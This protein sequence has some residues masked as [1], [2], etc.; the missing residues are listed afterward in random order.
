M[1]QE[2]T[3]VVRNA[4]K[5]YGKEQLV[6]NGL[7]MTVFKGSIYGLLGASGCGKTTLLS[8]IV[9]V[10]NF[11]SGEIWVL[12]GTP[13][14]KDSGIPGPR[15]GYMPQNIS[16][17]GEFSVRDAFY[18]FGRINGLDDKKIDE[19]QTFFSEFLQLPPL[20][21]LVKNMSGGQQRRVS[22]ASALIH[23]PELLILDEPTVGLDPILRENIWAYLTKLTQEDD[24]TVIITTHYIEEIKKANKIGLMR[25]GKLLAESTP[26]ELMEQFECSFLEEAFLK[27]CDAQNKAT[28]LN[29]RS[30]RSTSQEVTRSNVLYQ[31]RC[32]PTKGVSEC[33]AISGRQVS[34][35][36]RF[37]AVL[38]KNGVQFLR[39]Y[40][41]LIFAVFFPIIQSNLLLVSIGHDP[42]DIKIGIIN[43]EAGNCDFGSNFSSVWN[44]ESTCHFDNLSCRF[45][46]N[47]DDSI[48]IK[49]YY[50]DFSE[51]KRNVQNGKLCGIMYFNQNFSEGLQK[52]LEEGVFVED[53]DLN[54]SQIQVFLDMGD[55]QIGLFIQKKLFERFIEIS[56]NIMKDCKYSTK[57]A[58]LPINFKDPIYGSHDSSYTDFA[59][60]SF[61]LTLVFFLALTLSTT[62]IITDRLEGIW[63]RSVVQGVR[64]EEII[65]SH[66]LIQ[67][68]IIVIQT[69]VILL[70]C[71]VVWGINCKGSIFVV[72][73]L[74]F[75]N[76]FCGLMFG[77]V[78][79]VL[80]K[81]HTMASFCSAG[82][83]LPLMVINGTIWPLEGMPKFLRWFS[84]TMPITL[85]S[86]SMRSIMYKGSSI[87]EWQVFIGFIISLVWI[88]VY[89]L[90]IVL[91][92]RRKSS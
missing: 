40:I 52:R 43:E 4:I 54:A 59:I 23:S 74:L 27:L 12:G 28:T 19:K 13:G 75:L 79:S 33:K 21:C 58:N 91:C 66:I 51:A 67:S 24:V 22:F 88:S 55:R 37:K 18:Y 81:N 61:I 42:K 82:S 31:D 50:D 68:F 6:L 47:F 3:V 46:N 89:F 57:L 49:E 35:V 20:D 83:L 76:G 45:L 5:R 34:Q 1:M 38:K 30:G 11:N 73:F 65:L 56:E 36:K 72:S 64:T 84:Y 78:I 86:I 70:M 15:V 9:G 71:F 44:D 10:R 25:R 14:S 85:P 53:S 92:L 48:A 17:V 41:G 69:I 7:N 60:P 62:L 32:K 26:H 39:H 63:D 2:E 90:V 8:C 80:C 87:F 16:L 29:E 77:F